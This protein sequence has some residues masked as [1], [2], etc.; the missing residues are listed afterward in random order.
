MGEMAAM[1]H[2][3]CLDLLAG[4]AARVTLELVVLLE[5]LRAP[6]LDLHMVVDLG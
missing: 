6:G 5:A 2:G 3:D 4:I 1:D